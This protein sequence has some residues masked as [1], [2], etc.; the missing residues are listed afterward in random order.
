[1]RREV[2]AFVVNCTFKDEG[3]QWK[4][5]VRNLEVIYRKICENVKKGKHQWYLFCTEKRKQRTKLVA[6]F[7]CV[8]VQLQ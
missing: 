7:M 3:C 2:Q 5:E 4:G 1:M 8:V 6:N